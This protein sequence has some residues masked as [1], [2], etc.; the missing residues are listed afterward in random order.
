MTPPDLVRLTTSR[1]DFVKL[2]GASVA[3]A[4]LGACVREP[5]RKILPYVDTP[6][7]VVPGVPLHYAT[8]MTLDGYA[9]GLLVESHTGRP[10]KVEGNPDH[11]ASLGAAGVYEQASVLQLYDPHRARAVR[12][13]RRRATWSA[14]ASA[15]APAALAR[16]VGARGAGLRLLLPPTS[17]PLVAS[18]LERVLVRW[19]DAR[20]AFYAPLASDG[21]VAGTR[22]ALGAPLVPQY[23]FR[24]AD[25]VVSLD[26]DFLSSGPFHLRWASHHGVRR[27]ATPPCRLYVAEPVP[28]PTGTLAD[29]RLPIA[30]AG[31]ASLA[32][33]LL[34]AV[35]ADPRVTGRVGAVPLPAPSG[36]LPADARAWASAAAADLA[37]SPGRSIVLAGERQPAEVHAVVHALNAMLANAGATVWYTPPALVDAGSH[38]IGLDALA[39]ELDG[40]TVDTLVVLEG[41]PCYGAPA[42]LDLPRRMRAVPNSLY[43]GAYADETARVTTW[44]VPAAHYLESWGDARAYDGTTSLVQPLIA[45]L[46]DG[47]TPAE[48]LA[49]LAGAGERS[50]HDLL[51]DAW[52]ERHGAP[53][54]AEAAWSDALR[55]G[56][57]AGSAL[58]RATPPPRWDAVARAQRGIADRAGPS[59]DTTE[60]VFLPSRGVYDGRFADNAWLQELPD[61]ITK[62]TWDNAATM[63]PAHA[64][65][66]G[67]VTGDVVALRLGPRTL[68]VPAL[69]VPGQADG[70]VSLAIGYGRRGAEAVA[71][72][73]GANANLLR[74]SDAPHAATGLVIARTGRRHALALTQTHWSIE[75][76]GPS[77]LGE[78]PA[79]RPA[80]SERA[81][82]P[83]PQRKRRPLTLYEP[84]PPPKDGFGEDQ[85]A[86]VIDL[87]A[88]TGCSACV[89]AC[90]AENNV[91]VV[92]KEGVLDSREMHWLRIDRYVD[93]P[94]DAPRFETQP[95]LCQHC[96]KAPCEYVCPVGA[97]VHSDDGLNEM[98]YNRCVGTRFC[99][100]N[101][102]YKV[103]RFNWF[104]YNAEVAETVRMAKNPQVT[105]RGRGV[106]E[107][108]TFCV[109]RVRQAQRT[110]WLAGEPRTGPV[111][112][113]C[114]QTCPTHAIVFGSLT[115]PESEVRRLFDDPRGFSALGE[116]GTVPR[117]RYLARARSAPA[118]SADSPGAGA[119]GGG[120]G[121]DDDV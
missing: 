27:R 9:T 51:F 65:R 87:D 71:R 6:P 26:A 93:G 103:R 7:D 84:G 30:P 21:A 58:P 10:T 53:P 62:L 79:S 24:A 37:A 72:G 35:A 32:A 91:P 13:G 80:A 19:P 61:P 4:G 42:D 69:L 100:N 73:V 33:T 111:V 20:V 8:V 102:P 63:A 54:E 67:I 68:D 96:E 16:R 28:T 52:R 110:A 49:V 115:D 78:P 81:G 95:M 83:E 119:A 55:R 2:L 89:V 23:D 5:D 15:F 117:V 104:D 74:A 31:I 39:T 92:G 38:A 97:T 12:A 60:I 56:I 59:R 85:W 64:A 76:R 3:L 114:Q 46:H 45:P 50:A 112:T 57:V 11:P 108:C 48:V 105:V 66:L 22:T 121:D 40:R 34:H 75:G 99:S 77:V 29:H 120:G 82:A 109:Q 17:S 118:P 44:H 90:Q 18:L 113:A 88:C 14:A 86:M 94:L 116:L 107:K 41:N 70:V 47:R 1:R 36:T 106:M 101:C 98:I 25:V 43:L